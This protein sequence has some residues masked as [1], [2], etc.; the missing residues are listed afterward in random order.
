M[1]DHDNDAELMAA[2]GEDL[3][4]SINAMETFLTVFRA[5][6][7][8]KDVGATL[9]ACQREIKRLQEATPAMQEDEDAAKLRLMY[10]NDDYSRLKTKYDQEEAAREA[11]KYDDLRERDEDFARQEVFWQDRLV[12]AKAQHE[13]WMTS[14]TAERDRLVQDI[15]TH[16]EFL[17]S[18]QAQICTLR[19]QVGSIG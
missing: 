13:A 15:E 12:I 2:L 14:M 8:L 4:S 7:R 9:L 5:V 3:Q 17:T 6:S 10:L 19:Q 1:P 11:K 18:V 16:Q